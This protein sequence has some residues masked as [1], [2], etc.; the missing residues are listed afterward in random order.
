M[1]GMIWEYR[2]LKCLLGTNS[3]YWENGLLM[4]SRYQE[5][6]KIL[7]YF[8]IACR[9]QSG[10]LL[11]VIS[12]HMHVSL[13]E[14]QLL[15][16]LDDPTKAL[17]SQ[18][19][20]A[21]IAWSKRKEARQAIWHAAQVIRHVKALPPQTLRDFIAVV[22]YHASLV[23]WA[24][25]LS[26]RVR[27]AANPLYEPRVDRSRLDSL[28]SAAGIYEQENAWLDGEETEEIRRYISLERGVPAL[29]GN[30]PETALVL[31]DD[32]KSVLDV[33]LRVMED[34]YPV[35]PSVKKPPLVV[36]LIHLIEKVCEATWY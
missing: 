11:D 7:G 18:Q 31:L 35:Q 27:N 5:L 22:L 36:N 1:W 24:Y 6:A 29:R 28:A 14:I 25:G 12:M 30:Q 8:R 34:N 21:I 9:D 13:E 2:R 20:S 4:T 3:R 17:Q 10:M 32:P 26:L 23:L 19:S 16:T 33:V 15:A